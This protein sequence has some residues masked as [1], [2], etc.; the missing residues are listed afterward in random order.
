MDCGQLRLPAWTFM[1]YYRYVL[2]CVWL[3][4]A[5]PHWA[6]FFLLLEA[7]AKSLPSNGIHFQNCPCKYLV[8]VYLCICV[9]V[10]VRECIYSRFSNHFWPGTDVYVVNSPLTAALLSPTI[11]AAAVKMHQ[12]SFGSNSASISTADTE[13]Y[14]PASSM[15][16]KHRA[17]LP[18]HPLSVITKKMP[19]WAWPI[20]S[21]FSW[22]KL[23]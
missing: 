12:I 17:S 21:N 7:G 16:N 19:R 1:A 18:K 15:P 6:F 4:W 5:P 9:C 20:I 22:R 11:S 14:Q 3:W 23:I 2:V 13:S 10:C 8:C